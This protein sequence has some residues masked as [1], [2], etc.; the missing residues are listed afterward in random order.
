MFGPTRF[1]H[2]RR[3]LSVLLKC[4][5]QRDPIYRARLKRSLPAR[6]KTHDEG[7]EGAEL[8][9]RSPLKQRLAGLSA[10]ERERV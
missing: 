8:L 2:M 1:S 10:S 3:V 6:V 9:A 5:P 4:I 7:M